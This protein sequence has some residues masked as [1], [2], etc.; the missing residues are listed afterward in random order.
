MNFWI[1]KDSEKHNIIV[2]IPNLILVGSCGKDEYDNVE[3]QLKKNIPITTIVDKSKIKIIKTASIQKLKSLS[4]DDD[5]DIDY[6]E[7]GS[8]GSEEKDINI[9][10]ESPEQKQQ[11]LQVLNK[12]L[13]KHLNQQVHQK[14]L[15]ASIIP[16]LVSL[17]LAALA[18]FLYHSK[19]PMITYAV[20]GIWV[21]A[22]IVSL[23]KRF[24]NPPQVTQ[25]AID[26]NKLTKGMDFMKQAY[27]WAFVFVALV[28][29]SQ[30]LPQ[31]S[32]PGIIYDYAKKERLTEDNIADLL[33]KEADINYKDAQ[34]KTA[35]HYLIDQAS[36]RAYEISDN[37]LASAFI[38][39]ATGSKKSISKK[40]V[41]NLPE[42]VAI[43]LIKAGADVNAK[44][45]SG[46]SLLHYAIENY[47]E[48]ALS[49]RLFETMLKK[50]AK[51]DFVM[52]D[53][54]LSP[55]EYSKQYT[56]DTF[57]DKTRLSDLLAKYNNNIGNNI[58]HP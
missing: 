38:K 13:P 53:E 46:K 31:D 34:G 9:C 57:L 21:I 41:Q 30:I 19:L 32:G 24:K 22:S 16:S 43:A 26:K 40:K 28:A 23:Y 35:M 55:I 51:V 39:A 25:W 47:S 54:K 36:Y 1:N 2:A 10:F 45:N 17:A 12:I 5:I 49:P 56:N 20:G 44:D 52:G 7:V 58:G 14:S 3:E 50:G 8:K 29:V 11:C 6:L 37:I 27:A 33:N 48:E 15:L 18:I 4:T 42:I